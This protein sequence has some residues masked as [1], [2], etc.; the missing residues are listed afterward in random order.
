MTISFGYQGASSIG[1]QCDEE[2]KSFRSY[3]RSFWKWILVRSLS[4]Y[5]TATLCMS[6][7]LFHKITVETKKSETIEME[8]NASYLYFF[9]PCAMFTMD[10]V[11]ILEKIKY[12][13]GTKECSLTSIISKKAWDIEIFTD[14][15]QLHQYKLNAS[16]SRG[17]MSHVTFKEQD[18]FTSE[19]LQGKINS[20]FFNR[21]SHY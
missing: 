8:L 4:Y 19:L 9:L 18:Y 1:F 12:H 14:F 5:N 20:H 17:F 16:S 2:T 15:C 11:D 21:T 6:Y 3:H 7:Y 13:A 10:D